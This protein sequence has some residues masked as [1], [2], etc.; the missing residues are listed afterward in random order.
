MELGKFNL[1]ILCEGTFLVDGG[2]MFG[3]VPKVLWNKYNSSDELNRIELSL[4]C[5]LIQTGDKNILIDTGIGDKVGDKL[6]KI[7]GINRKDDWLLEK[8]KPEDIDIVINTHLHF[9]H[10]GGNTCM[11]DG[12]LFPTFKNAKYFIQ[13]G[14]W[15]EAMEPNERAKGSYLKENLL[16]IKECNLLNL[17]EGDTE[18]C[19]GVKTLVTGGHTAYHQAVF[20]ESDGNK[21]IYLGDFIPTVSFLNKSYA[22][23]YDLY[24]LEI[25][26]NKKE[27]LQKAFE[28]HWLLIFDHDTKVAMGYLDKKEEKFIIQQTG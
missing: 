14:E 21:A 19:P 8:I 5:L 25:M 20:I 4:N 18:I 23:A 7:Y 26:N 3:V 12:I 28:E 24:P 9:D 13:K 27:I 11:K 22:S 10:C 2:A 6:K 16:P 1:T 15:E 17:I